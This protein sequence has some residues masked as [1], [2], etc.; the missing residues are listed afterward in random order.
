MHD[1]GA[2]NTTIIVSVIVA[3][4]CFAFAILAAL[5]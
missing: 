5:L 2:S 3:G 1:T 4:A